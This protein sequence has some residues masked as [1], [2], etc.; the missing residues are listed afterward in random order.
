M[1]ARDGAVRTV[2]RRTATVL[3]AILDQE[4]IAEDTDIVPKKKNMFLRK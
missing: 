1:R 2:N 4:G 3:N